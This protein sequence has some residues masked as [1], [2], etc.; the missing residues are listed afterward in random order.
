MFVVELGNH[1]GDRTY[2]DWKLDKLL[3]EQL[4]EVFLFF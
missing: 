3:V 2:I 1:F 4:E